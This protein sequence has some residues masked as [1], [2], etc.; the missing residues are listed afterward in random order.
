ME[1]VD[2]ETIVNHLEAICLA[3]QAMPQRELIRDVVANCN[4]DIRKS[5]LKLQF[6]LE[7][8]QNPCHEAL[9]KTISKLMGQGDVKEA[10]PVVDSLSEMKPV[11]VTEELVPREGHGMLTGSAANQEIKVFSIYH[12]L[13]RLLEAPKVA[14]FLK[15]V[16]CSILS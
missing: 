11:V 6:L 4:G 12:F 8:W 13:T 16:S 9:S 3:E 7:Q 10:L 5:L 14:N 1:A 15:L 2:Y